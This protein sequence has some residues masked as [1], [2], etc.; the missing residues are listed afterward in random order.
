MEGVLLYVGYIGICGAKGYGFF[1]PFWSEMGYGLC[2]LVL[3]WVC[4]FEEATSSSFG[5]K[6]ISPNNVYANR[7]SAV[8]ACHALWSRAG[9]QGFRSEIG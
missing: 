7:V 5:D 3:N 2:T 1:Q 6:T 8:T 4:F 9:F